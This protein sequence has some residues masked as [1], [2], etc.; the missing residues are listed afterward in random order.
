MDADE[1]L[2]EDLR[3][4][5]LNPDR[6]V[7]LLVSLQRQLHAANQRIAD[8]EKRLAG[9]SPK[10]EEPY[11]L[12]SEEKRQDARGKKKRRAQRSGRRGRLST[13][14]KIANAERE[15]DVLPDG[16]AKNECRLSHTRPVWRLENGRAV[17][18]AYPTGWAIAK[19]LFRISC[20]PALDFKH[21]LFLPSI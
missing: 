6:L 1:Q 9:S 10:V 15:V 17:L 16:L 3:S 7:E 14:D 20:E 19:R 4:G 8:L 21:Q 18:V 5:R 2:T 11:S 12:R 13:A